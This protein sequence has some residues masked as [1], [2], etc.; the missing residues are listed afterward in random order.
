MEKVKEFLKKIPDWVKAVVASAV[1][2]AVAVGISNVV[3]AVVHRNCI[4]VED[5]FSCVFQIDSVEQIADDFVLTGWAFELNKNAEKKD[6]DIILYDYKNDNKFYT[7][8]EDIS[9]KD[10]NDYFFCEYDYSESGFKASIKSKKL[11]LENVNYEVLIQKADSRN[12]I[13]T[14][15]YVSKGKLM[16]VKPEDYVALQVQ[17]TELEE[18]INNGILRVYRPDVGMYV[19]QY[20]GK[21]YWI[22]DENY[23]FKEG[24]LTAIG[25]S[26]NTT[27]PEKLPQ[28]RVDNG[29]DWDN[30][31][32]FFEDSEIKDLRVGFYRVA[33]AEIPTDYA[34]TKITF[35]YYT[36]DWEC[37]KCARPVYYFK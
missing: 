33:V 18:V 29:W 23:E 25:Y 16:N 11:D 34:I 10:V 28:H 3:N 36:N 13:S 32:Y 24:G 8:V 7:K 37:L 12:A 15:V 4:I 17:G 27:Q 26:L 5:D 21:L 31:S 2:I 14:G 30:R 19:Y 1:I 22:A 35:D 9:R 20:A 6:F